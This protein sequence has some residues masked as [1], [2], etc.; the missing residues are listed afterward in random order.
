MVGLLQKIFPHFQLAKYFCQENA[1]IDK[2]TMLEWVQ[3]IL[4]PFIAI[5]PENVVPLLMLESC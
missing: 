2:G 1:W 3:K 4:K 5:E